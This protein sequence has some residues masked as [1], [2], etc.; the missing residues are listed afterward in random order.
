[1]YGKA[2]KSR[3]GVEHETCGEWKKEW[4]QFCDL[5]G[6]D[7][8]ETIEKAARLYMSVYGA[9]RNTAHNNQKNKEEE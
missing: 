4:R 8:A 7:Q 3:G 2:R 9:R 5:H 6:L 1:M